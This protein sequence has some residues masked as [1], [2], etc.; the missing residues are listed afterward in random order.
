ML[1][2]S[3]PHDHVLGVIC[4][5]RIVGSNCCA[6]KLSPNNMI[7]QRSGFVY[8]VLFVGGDKLCKYLMGLGQGSR[9]APPSLIPL[10][11]VIVK[12]LRGLYHGAKIA[13]PITRSITHTVGL[14]FVKDTDLYC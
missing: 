3:Q 6:N 1:Q 7:F 2:Q 13:N 9:G 11:S 10:S 5:D 4:P 14:I 12:V 8:S